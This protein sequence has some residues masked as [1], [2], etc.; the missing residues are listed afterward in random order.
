M[1]GRLV[2]T[3]RLP[4]VADHGACRTDRRAVEEA[5]KGVLDLRSGSR[6]FE[7]EHHWT[8]S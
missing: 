1:L 5:P 2:Q 4:A 8:V 3:R 7:V 6:R